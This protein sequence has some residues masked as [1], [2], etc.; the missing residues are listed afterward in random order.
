MKRT[1]CFLSK[2][3]SFKRSRV[4]FNWDFR[5]YTGHKWFRLAATFFSAKIC[6]RLLKSGLNNKHR[7]WGQR[8]VWTRHID[9]TGSF[10]VIGVFSAFLP[11]ILAGWILPFTG[12]AYT[13]CVHT[14]LI[15]S[16]FC[17]VYLYSG[18]FLRLTWIVR[19]VIWHM[20]PALGSWLPHFF[21]FFSVK[22]L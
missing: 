20:R 16:Y 1:S 15:K 14:V 13:V 22:D 17:C 4:L 21:S 11:G 7:K 18:C 19:L 6:C 3:I 9:N 12:A 2:N 8:E 10:V 5:F